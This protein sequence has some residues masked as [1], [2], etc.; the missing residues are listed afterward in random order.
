MS[1]LDLPAVEPFG[2]VFLKGLGRVNEMI[3]FGYRVAGTDTVLSAIEMPLAVAQ[4]SV[5]REL[6]IELNLNGAVVVSLPA[7]KP[8]PTPILL[9]LSRYAMTFKAL[10]S[11]EPLMTLSTRAF[12]IAT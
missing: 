8:C 7:T 10:P 6:A 11:G 3:R 5:S 2:E 4:Q 12:N 9:Q 1:S